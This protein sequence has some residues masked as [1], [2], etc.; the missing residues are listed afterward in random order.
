MAFKNLRKEVEE[1]F[2]ELT[3][4]RED[5]QSYAEVAA[6]FAKSLGRQNTQSPD[7]THNPGFHVIGKKRSPGRLAPAANKSRK[8]YKRAHDQKRDHADI[9]TRLLAG[10]RPPWCTHG[11]GRPPARWIEVAKELGIEL[12]SPFAAKKAKAAWVPP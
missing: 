3:P 2:G 9:R 7:Q 12:T 4:E 10:E 8:E 1:M 11:R 6:T 5:P